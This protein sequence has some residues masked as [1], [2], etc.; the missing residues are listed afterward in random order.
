MAGS[1]C[2]TAST[3]TSFQAPPFVSCYCL[4]RLF[5]ADLSGQ[6]LPDSIDMDKLS[7]TAVAGAALGALLIDQLDACKEVR[8]THSSAS[9]W[10]SRR[11]SGSTH[12]RRGAERA[13]HR[14]AGRLEGG[15]PHVF[16]QDSR[17]LNIAVHWARCPA[18][19]L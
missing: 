8:L 1:G 4:Q 2:W 7:G 18:G 3:C 6:Q 9:N 17:T 19:C 13:A 12:S 5:M 10:A 16:V 11:L 14:P 15:G